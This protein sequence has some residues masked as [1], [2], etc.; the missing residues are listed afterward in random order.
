MKFKVHAEGIALDAE[1]S[2]RLQGFE[3]QAQRAVVLTSDRDVLAVEHLRIALHAPRQRLHEGEVLV[4]AELLT[5]HV[6]ALLPSRHMPTAK[7]N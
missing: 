7:T 2:T 6:A 3:V 5:L 1:T 4:V